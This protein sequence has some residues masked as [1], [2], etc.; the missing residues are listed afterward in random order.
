M[1]QILKVFF[2]KICCISTNGGNNDT[3]NLYSGS[4]SQEKY[5]S[6]LPLKLPVPGLR[7]Q[8]EDNV[9]ANNVDIVNIAAEGYNGSAREAGGQDNN[10]TSWHAQ[11]A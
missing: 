3:L 11:L 4:Q 10:D 5:L 1:M 8:L 2:F 6:R 7:N 9:Q